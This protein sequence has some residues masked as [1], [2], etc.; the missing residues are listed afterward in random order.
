M[1]ISFVIAAFAAPALAASVFVREHPS[2]LQ[3]DALH[4]AGA[5]NRGYAHNLREEVDALS[6]LLRRIDAEDASGN[7]GLDLSNAI[8]AREAYRP[9]RGSHGPHGHDRHH[10]ARDLMYERD[11]SME[12]LRRNAHHAH[13]HEHLF[14]SREDTGVITEFLRR[15]YPTPPPGTTQPAHSAQPVVQHVAQH[16]APAGQPA[17]APYLPTPNATP[18]THNQPLPPHRHSDGSDS[19]LQRIRRVYDE[20]LFAARDLE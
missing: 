13:G 20:L 3:H 18:H 17:H 8:Y 7:N 19:R 15:M 2:Q 14:A 4:K 1:R 11:V 5:G 12:M 6:E 10:A 9:A 16:A